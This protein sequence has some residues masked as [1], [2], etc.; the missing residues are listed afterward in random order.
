ML[1]IVSHMGIKDDQASFTQD[2]HFKE[3][4]A[5]ACAFASAP[6]ME[7]MLGHIHTESQLYIAIGFGNI[8]YGNLA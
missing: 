5:L 4:V 1:G 3:A 6:C 8:H 2:F 7:S